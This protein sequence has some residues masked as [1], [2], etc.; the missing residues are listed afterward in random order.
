[1]REY[2]DTIIKILATITIIISLLLWV[3]NIVF[4]QPSFLWILT[5]VFSG[6]GLLLA[7]SIKSKV[8]II[9][10]TI[11]FFSFF[12]VMF[13]GYLLDFLTTQLF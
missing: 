1:R 11:T 5:F 12:L 7:V 2:M 6:I 4:Q 9:G 10:N 13:F 3:P 8:L